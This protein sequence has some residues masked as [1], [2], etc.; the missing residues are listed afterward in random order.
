[1]GLIKLNEAKKIVA[2]ADRYVALSQ[3]LLE[4]AQ[5]TRS[6]EDLVKA[7]KASQDSEAAMFLAK[8]ALREVT[9]P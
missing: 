1:M 4:R 6:E 9:G 2:R 8:L 5:E 7:E 3:A